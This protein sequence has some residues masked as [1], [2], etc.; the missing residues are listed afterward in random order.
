MATDGKA[1]AGRRRASAV[2]AQLLS[3][4]ARAGLLLGASAAVYAVT[5]ASISGL[6]ADTSGAANAARAS[7]LDAVT[8][9]R[10][11]NDRL[12]ASLAGVDAGTRGLVASYGTA[13][14]ATTAYES[15]LDE[16]AKLVAE[17]Q[18]TAAALP[19]RIQLPAVTTHGA[20]ASARRVPTTVARTGASGKP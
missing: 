9:A 17:V 10:A 15:R 18:G 4:P 8:Q 20:V 11:A 5:L 16:L 3:T 2:N 19:A 12:Q 13:S 6:Q 1:L 14:T 7:Q